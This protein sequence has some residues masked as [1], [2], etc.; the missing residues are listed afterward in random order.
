MQ[1]VSAIL[2]VI[3][4]LTACSVSKPVVRSNTVNR[5]TEGSIVDLSELQKQNITSHSFHIQ[6]AEVEIN[7]QG[8]KQRF[9]ASV[10]FNKPDTFLISVR[11][12]T[13]I[14][15]V[16]IFATKDT[17]LINDRINR[18]FFYGTQNALRKKYGLS[19]MLFPV[20]LGDVIK[21]DKRDE[22]QHKC[23]TGIIM[24]DSYLEGKKIDY[25]ID[26][27]TLKA[28]EINITRESDT[29]PVLIKYSDFKNVYDIVFAERMSIRDLNNI[30]LID[31]KFS[32]VEVPW[33]GESIF[34]PGNNYERIEIK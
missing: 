33:V 17:V 11:S 26:C 25:S 23:E 30:D 28:F 5:I 8:E 14:E 2:L 32:K 13:G 31:V 20:L 3:L 24:L 1:K 21:A 9:F 4:Y 6:K 29:K 34:I 22:G 7:E 10:K 19:S 15:A 16:R 27:E 12:T 18:I